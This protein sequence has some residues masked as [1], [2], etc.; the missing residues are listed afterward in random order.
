[1]TDLPNMEP[2]ELA[3]PGES[4]KRAE[5]ANLRY[6][7]DEK[8]GFSRQ[9]VGKEF[10][11]Y[12]L[13]GNF[14]KDRK[15]LD[16]IDGLAIPPAWE[17][18][19]ICSKANGHIQATGRDEKG[20]KQYRYHEKWNEISNEQKFHK[21]LSFSEILPHLRDEVD[22]DMGLAGLTQEKIL[23]TIVWLLENTYIRV[24]NEEYARA[25]N[26]FGLTTLRNK[27]VEVVG[28]TVTFEFTGKSGKKHL[29][30]ITDPLV[31]KTLRKLEDLPG[32]EL[33]QYVDENGERHPIDSQD[34]NDYLKQIAGD[35][36]SAKDFRT[37]GGTVLSAVT[38]KQLGEFKN[39][40]EALKNINQAVKT[41]ATHLRNTPKISK[42]YYIHPVVPDTYQKKEL[43][44]FFIQ[45]SDKKPA[46]NLTKNEFGVSELLRAFS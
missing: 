27:H 28:G 22:K 6:V 26:H 21:M 24:G 41:V 40:K 19:W 20:R 2:A 46:R 33:F 37:W 11:Y 3:R 30:V 4:A 5:E 16:R 34:V 1:M 23:A 44:P 45:V 36:V 25:N 29:V 35:N 17:D 14:I 42:A 31:V 15:T 43:I 9:K 12:D 10:R 7:S 38:L 18:I 8:P 39:K 13:E 32:Y